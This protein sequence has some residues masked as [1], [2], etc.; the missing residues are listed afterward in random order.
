MAYIIPFSKRPIIIG[1]GFHGSSHRY[2]KKDREDFSKRLDKAISSS[3]N[4]TQQSALL[5][6]REHAKSL[7][8]DATHEVPEL[9]ESVVFD[10]SSLN[11]DA[12]TFYAELILRQVWKDMT[13]VGHRRKNTLICVDEAHRLLRTF[14]KYESIYGE[15]SREIRAFG[16]LWTSMQNFT[17]IPDKVRNQFATQ[18]LFNTNHQDDLVALRAIDEK[19]SWAASSLPKHCFTDARYEWIHNVVPEYSLFV[20]TEDKERNYYEAQTDA[21]PLMLTLPQ[22]RPTP[23]IHA[24]LLAIQYNKGSDMSALADWLRAK[25]FITSNNTI[26]GYGTRQ[27]VFDTA[28]SLGF[29]EKAKKGYKLAEKGKKWVD[30]ETI[31]KNEVNAGSEL[32]KQILAKTI[33]KLHETNTLVV[34]PKERQAFDLI[35]YPVDKGKKQLWDDKAKMAYEIQTTARKDKVMANAEKRARG[36]PITWV[37]CDANVLKNI[38]QETGNKDFYMMVSIN[39]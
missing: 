23:T 19:L 37:A 21:E 14:E 24:A 38:K 15:M 9:E 32:H 10:F 26:Y 6:V 33:E 13:E 18:F 11:E 8:N 1:Q 7:Y 16:L 29:I 39:E 12:K 17:D 3:K 28:V 31:L 4:Q 30:A 2:W 27:S 34:A 20:K 36:V 35:A 25:G 22:N 5:F